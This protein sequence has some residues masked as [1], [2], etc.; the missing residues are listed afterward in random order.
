MICCT[1]SGTG[2]TD[3]LRVALFVEGSESPPV[4]R[5][6]R[7]LE[8]IW[9]E[10]LPRALGLRTFSS[11]V[12]ISKTHLVA[13]DP[14]K[15]PMSGAGEGLD[16]RMVRVLRRNPF[17]AAVI[18]WDLVPAWNPQGDFCRWQETLALY[19]HLSESTHLDDAW[20]TSAAQRLAD[21][22]GRRTPAARTRPPQLTHHMILALCMEPMFEGLLVQD[23]AAVKQALG[24]RGKVPGWPRQGWGDAQERR[25]DEQLLAPAV[26]AARSQAPR[27]IAGVR[28]DWDVNKDGWGEFLLR[29]LLDDSKACPQVLAHP[30]CQRLAEVGPQQPP[31]RRGSRRGPQAESGTGRR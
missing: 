19:R 30:L 17:D 14:D 8:S 23:E 5:G 6:I 27:I 11:V 4:P 28:G 13:M 29:R 9:N 18:A 16:Q 12:P 15:P 20:K 31:A 24:L 3:D 21:L 7:S 22:E 1:R 25:P 26:N 10:H 2:V